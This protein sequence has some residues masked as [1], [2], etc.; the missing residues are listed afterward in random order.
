MFSRLTV[1][2]VG[3]LAAGSVFADSLLETDQ[4]LC[5]PG[6]VTH[7][8]SGGDCELGPPENYN[9]PEFVRI[10]LQ[11]PA[12]RTTEASGVDQST[13]IEH[14]IRANGTIYLQGVESG[15]A[16]SIVIVEAT[17]DLSFTV[18]S[19]GETAS[20]FGACTPA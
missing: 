8:S 13:P 2:C 9:L 3:L 5:A 1:F 19:D 6:Y 10:D 12:L 7:C 15:R 18:V 16:Y 17:G 4:L 20:A 11:N 14:V